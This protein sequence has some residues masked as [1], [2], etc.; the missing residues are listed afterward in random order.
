MR[1]L[2]F[3]SLLFILNILIVHTNANLI[4]GENTRTSINWTASCINF[5]CQTTKDLFTS[6]KR[7]IPTNNIATRV[8]VHNGCIYTAY[9]RY[10]EGV[11]MTLGVSCKLG[12]CGA[13]FDPF[14]CWKYQEESNCDALQSVVDFTIDH[15]GILWALDTG[16]TNSMTN[17][18]LRRCAPK[19]VLINVETKKVI[20]FI[21]L[22][23]LITSNSRL[24]S[25]IVDYDGDQCLVYISDAAT[26]SIIVYNVKAKRGYRLVLPQNVSKGSNKRDVLYTA[27][28]KNSERSKLYF[29]YLSARKIYSIDSAHL[30]S[31]NRRGKIVGE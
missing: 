30:R 27:L 10:L 12:G 23:T 6:S 17:N 16:I 24:Q 7:Y 2:V 11:P 21:K 1:V 25:L 15:Q 18:P 8:Q 29:T 20:R 13:N 5:P 28:V 31:G 3:S 4:S 9:P 22:D 19:I 26:R 14:P